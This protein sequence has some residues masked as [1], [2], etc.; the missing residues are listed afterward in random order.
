M[1]KTFTLFSRQTRQDRRII[2]TLIDK[3]KIYVI[4]VI[5]SV[6]FWRKRLKVKPGNFLQ[7]FRWTMETRCMFSSIFEHQLVS[8]IIYRRSDQWKVINLVIN[9]FIQTHA[10]FNFHL[11]TACLKIIIIFLQ[12]HHP[13]TNRQVS[14]I[15]SAEPVYAMRFFGPIYLLARG[16]VDTKCNF[17]LWN[18]NWLSKLKLIFAYWNMNWK[19][20]PCSVHYF[21]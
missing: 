1:R 11:C 10:W 5:G 4:E 15:S 6:N 16:T 12:G 7:I 18:F 14:V 9:A 20:L 8:C 17:Q 13:V 21:D 3:L 2:H 19:R